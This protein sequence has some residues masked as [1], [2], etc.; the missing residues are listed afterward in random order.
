LIELDGA[1]LKWSV[2]QMNELT[3]KA[4]GQANEAVGEAKKAMK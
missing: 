1:E 2:R 3:G 4:K